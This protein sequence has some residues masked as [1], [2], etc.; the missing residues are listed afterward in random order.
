MLTEIF[1]WWFKRRRKRKEE[2]HISRKE[3]RAMKKE[4]RKRKRFEKRYPGKRRYP[5]H[6]GE[7]EFEELYRKFEIPLH[8]AHS[9]IVK[10]SV[11]EEYEHLIG[12]VV[13]I[14]FMTTEKAHVE[15]EVDGKVYNYQL[16]VDD[17]Q[18]G[19]IIDKYFIQEGEWF[20]MKEDVRSDDKSRG[21]FAKEGEDVILLKK[22][23]NHEEFDYV[24][25][26]F[27]RNLFFYVT[28]DEV[29]RNHQILR[30]R[31]V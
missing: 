28:K 2:G 22:L 30:T 26:S 18:F 15:C 14:T 27:E 20:R 12:K 19:G 13:Y 11:S 31:V 25:H 24:M 9:A 17:L 21:Y 8:K 16:N 23:T 4:E 5:Q 7:R 29:E 6:V 10:D 3:R 1:K